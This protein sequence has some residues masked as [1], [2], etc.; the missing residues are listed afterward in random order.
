MPAIP[1]LCCFLIV[2]CSGSEDP[3][4]EPVD[5]GSDVMEVDA[6]ETA[7]PDVPKGPCSGVADD[8]AC[9]DNNA[10][11]EDDTCQSGVCI[12]GTSTT[13]PNGPGCQVGV[14]D[15]ASGCGLETAADGA[16]CSAHCFNEAVCTAGEC[17]GV[18]GKERVCEAPDEP[19]VASLACDAETGQCTIPT[20]KESGDSCDS[21]KNQ[22]TVEVCTGE[23]ACI[24]LDTESCT[25]ERAKQPCWEW[26][27]DPMFGCVQD[28]FNDGEPCDDDSDEC[29]EDV[30]GTT[31]D[32]LKTCLHVPIEAEDGPCGPE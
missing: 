18:A 5:V 16:L 23:H 21:D 11:T 26:K 27:C 10:C 28:D 17:A 29:T 32:D 7:E 3:P 31:E 13:C 12:G 30:C 2:A 14:C 9:D 22:C 25:T 1:L 15:A 6:P 24:T 19:C 4:A 20:W 8:T